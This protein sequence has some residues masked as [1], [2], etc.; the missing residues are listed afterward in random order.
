MNNQEIQ[1][2]D[3]LTLDL[4]MDLA[5]L[6]SAVGSFDDNLQICDLINFVKKIYKNSEEIRNIFN[7]SL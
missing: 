6:N 5:I 7:D 4:N 3:E 2:L 1:K